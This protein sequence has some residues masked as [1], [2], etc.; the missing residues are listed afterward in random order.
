MKQ[1]YQKIA[2]YKYLGAI[3]RFATD[4]KITSLVI[5]AVI[6]FAVY[7]GIGIWSGNNTETRYVLAAVERGT[8]TVAITASGQVSAANQVDIKAKASGDVVYIGAKNGNAVRAG[9]LIAQLDTR[10]AQKAVRDAE[11]NLESAKIALAKLK[12]PADDLSLI[13]TQNSLAQAEENL[14]KDYDETFNN[15]ADAFLD[16]PSIISGLQDV[17]YGKN[18]TTGQDNIAAYTDMVKSYNSAAVSIKNAAVNKYI[19][20]RNSY[21]KTFVIYKTVTRSSGNDAIADLLGESYETVKN[22]ADAVKSASNLLDLVKKELSERNLN[23]PATLAAHQSSLADYATKINSHL[24]T[25][26]DSKNSIETDRR[27]IAEKKESWADVKRGADDLD[28]ASQELVVRQKENAL[29]DAK[30]KLADY[31]IRAP[32]DGVLTGFDLKKS[33]NVTS[34]SAVATVIT[35]D[36]FAEISLNEVDIPEIKIDQKVNLIFDAVA[37]LN[38]KGHVAEIDSVGTVNQGVVTYNAKIN[39]DEDDERV[40]PG[41]SVS[42]DITTIVKADVLMVPLSAVKTQGRMRYVETVD[43]DGLGGDGRFLA[44]S[45]PG[46]VLP[47]PPSRQ[48]VEIGL[49]GETNTEITNGLNE[50]DVVVVRTIA[51]TTTTPSPQA[52]SL[53]GPARGGNFRAQTR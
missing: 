51:P 14:K 1:I 32:F 10:E 29:L 7:W 44:G 34:G 43:R 24:N 8:L 52:P 21:D 18:I 16:L 26:L 11:V 39:F 37:D 15:I 22:A 28:L 19:A 20:A 2:S 35:P 5:A 4:H 40:K 13:Q 33:D 9:T 3:I 46:L 30:E 27:A 47:T 42:A 49:A 23:T 36:K 25:L 31:Y 50:G 41:M 38:L 48:P 6:V 17:F 45:A 53:F 12:K